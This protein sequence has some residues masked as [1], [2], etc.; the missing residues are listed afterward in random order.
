MGRCTAQGPRGHLR[1]TGTSL[2]PHLVE[3]DRAEDVNAFGEELLDV[4][5]Q[6]G[7]HRGTGDNESRTIRGTG[8]WQGRREG[9][10][11]V[12]GHGDRWDVRAVWGHKGRRTWGCGWRMW[13]ESQHGDLRHMG[14]IKG[15]WDG[16]G[17]QG[18]PKD[19]GTMGGYWDNLGYEDCHRDTGTVGEHWDHLEP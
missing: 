9:T 4:A 12:R 10:G 19:V 16:L 11:T 15:Y 13:G 1:D 7:V 18:P 5:E 8:D 3:L 2:W 14:I 6:V 17:T